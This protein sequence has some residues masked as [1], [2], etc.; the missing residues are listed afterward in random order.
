MAVFK[1]VL[2]KRRLRQVPPQFSWIDH[3]LVRD[4]HI[5]RCSSNALALYLFLV[6]V[7]DGQ[8]LSYY[9]DQT[10]CRLLP[11]LDG[12][13]LSR[14]RAELVASQLIAYQPPLYQVLALGPALS[15]SKEP[16]LSLSKGPDFGELP[17]GLTSASSVEPSLRVEASRG[18]SPSPQA[19]SPQARSSKQTQSIP[20][21]GPAADGEGPHPLARILREMAGLDPTPASPRTAPSQKPLDSTSFDTA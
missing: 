20:R 14:A 16:A 4:R 12:G 10:I 15:L 19:P 18:A 11:A 21:T 7:A 1:R 2:C 9:A 3:R 5:S 8:G 6:T 13:S 17:S